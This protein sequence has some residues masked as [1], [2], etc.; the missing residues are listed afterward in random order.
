MFIE[1]MFGVDVGRPSALFQCR[2]VYT[3]NKLCPRLDSHVYV[4]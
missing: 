2:L 3:Y 4:K 1:E